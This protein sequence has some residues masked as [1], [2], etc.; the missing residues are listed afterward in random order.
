MQVHSVAFTGSGSGSCIMNPLCYCSIVST[1][2]SI[3]CLWFKPILQTADI[4]FVVLI[5]VGACSTHSRCF[6]YQR[7]QVGSQMELKMPQGQREVVTW[8]LLDNPVCSGMCSQH[9]QQHHSS[10][11]HS[12]THIQSS[13]DNIETGLASNSYAALGLQAPQQRCL[14]YC[15]ARPPS[16]AGTANPQCTASQHELDRQHPCT[17]EQAHPALVPPQCQA[18]C[19]LCCTFTHVLRG[20]HE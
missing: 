5:G 7:Q 14:C 15:R 11:L 17:G 13:S 2:C 18:S 19:V 10:I 6:A 12:H 4:E 20:Q 8:H 3:A 9:V 16:D 1:A